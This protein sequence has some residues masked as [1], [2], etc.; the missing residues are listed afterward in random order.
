[1]LAVT[2]LL[3]GLFLGDKNKRYLAL[4]SISGIIIALL[5]EGLISP[6]SKAIFGQLFLVDQPAILFKILFLIIAAYVIAI[7]VEWITDSDYLSEYYS[8]PVGHATAPTATSIMVPI[9][10]LTAVQIIFGVHPKL[11]ISLIN[12]RVKSIVGRMGGTVL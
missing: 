10:I 6:S 2:V 5:F 7:S 4:L 8:F 3:L 1:L 9:S 12:M 11:L